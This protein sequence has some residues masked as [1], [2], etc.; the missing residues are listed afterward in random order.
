MKKLLL[1]FL[2]SILLF[3]YSCRKDSFITSKDALIRL[4][5]DTIYF[6]TVFT[7]A[8]SITQP[9]KI[10]NTNNQRLLLSSV[11]LMGGSGSPFSIN[12]GG[13]AAAERTNIEVAAGDSV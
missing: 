12:V 1:L 8:G 5:S 3:E 4:S 10:I 9:V 13:M 6:D 11:K 2:S 7:T